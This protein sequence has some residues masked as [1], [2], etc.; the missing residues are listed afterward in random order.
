MTKLRAKIY[1][2][3]SGWMYKDWNKYFYP[4]SV[5]GKSQ[6]SYYAK[7]FQTVEVNS[8]FYRTPKVSATEGWYDETPSSFVF[9]VKLSQYITHKKRLIL[10]NESRLR[11]SL[12]IKALSPISGEI[13]ALL[14]QLP[15]SFKLN[16][17]RLESFLKEL[18]A[19]IPSNWTIC[20]EFRHKSWLDKDAYTLLKKY[21]VT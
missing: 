12:F 19:K 7:H 13:K 15:P 14:V 5:K 9:V 20:L 21:E 6:L 11:L 16:L 10:D 17:K 4:K 3:T 8:T 18:K 1:V 2:G